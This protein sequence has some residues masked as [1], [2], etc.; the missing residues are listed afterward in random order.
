MTS[1]KR[2]TESSNTTHLKKRRILR[3]TPN[4]EYIELYDGKMVDLLLKLS[5]SNHP[6]APDWLNDPRNKYRIQLQLEFLSK[7]PYCNDEKEARGKR[8]FRIG[9]TIHQRV[10]YQQSRDQDGGFGSK[11]PQNSCNYQQM[12]REVRSCL[13]EKY[14]VDA[15][16]DNAHFRLL[17]DDCEDRG[18]ACEKVRNYVKNRVKLVKT[19]KEIHDTTREIAKRAFI[20]ILY[21]KDKANPYK[22]FVHKYNFK[23]NEEAKGII[24]TLVKE[25][26]VIRDKIL[27]QEFEEG[28]DWKLRT[29]K[30]HKGAQFALYMQTKC[31]KALDTLVQCIRNQGFQADSLIHDGCLIRKGQHDVNLELLNVSFKK[32]YK[33]GEIKIKPFNITLDENDFTGLQ[34]YWHE[35]NNIV[36]KSPPL[37]RD[38]IIPNDTP[39][40]RN[41]HEFR[42][43]QMHLVANM[44]TVVAYI[45]SKNEY[46]VKTGV[47]KYEVKKSRLDTKDY[48]AD[49][50]IWPIVSNKPVGLINAFELWRKSKYRLM[51][52]NKVCNP[53]PAGHVDG[54]KPNEFNVFKGFTL[55]YDDVK[56]DNGDPSP[57][58]NHITNIWCRNDAV[59]AK[60]VIQFFAQMLQTPWERVDWGIFLR[61][62]QGSM[63]NFVLD[64][65]I[66][67]IL[68]DNACF[69]THD[70]EK[71]FGKFNKHLEGMILIGNDEAVSAYD[72]KAISKLKGFTTQTTIMIEDKGI[73]TY[74]VEALHRLITFSNDEEYANVG[75]GQRRGFFLE[76]DDTY[77]DVNCR[78]PTAASQRQRYIDTCLGC[79]A[80]TVAKFLYEYDISDFNPRRVIHTKF[81]QQQIEGNLS[82]V[83]SFALGIIKEDVYFSCYDD[84]GPSSR[85]LNSPIP[86]DTVFDTFKDQNS[87]RTRHYA[88]SSF[89]KELKRIFP[90]ARDNKTNH[91]PCIVFG[92]S[93]RLKSDFRRHVKDPNWRF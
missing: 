8:L 33:H 62:L 93:E 12:K 54:P 50:N 38:E 42:A 73:S 31:T 66:K 37:T 26:E 65:W 34:P 46:I 88:K 68:G 81:E 51:Y 35:F 76:T 72:K 75:T 45:T 70:A 89:W 69:V 85:N 52:N 41:Q 25:V 32:H 3:F 64:V 90:S 40:F 56:D 5:Q 16:M 60:C 29:N 1:Y 77:A 22:A 15:D 21:S 74:Q 13:A 53:R 79:S 87:A 84:D 19:L 9:D 80:Q 92:T 27:Q 4:E 14:Y 59:A 10:Q 67:K 18:I 83:E 36:L 58:V 7:A 91:V 61:G 30:D 39:T 78:T 49:Y 17:M 48:F 2:H 11:Y 71:I 6:N 44:N 63:K 55:T 57:F 20:S 82:P 23:S 47:E 86:K 43:W 28:I 24:N